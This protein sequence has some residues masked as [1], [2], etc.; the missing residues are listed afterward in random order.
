MDKRLKCT[1][2]KTGKDFGKIGFVSSLILLAMGV[3]LFLLYVCA[4]YTAVVVFIIS[5]IGSF[6]AVAAI[7]YKNYVKC[8][9][10]RFKD[11]YKSSD[12]F[13]KEDFM[14]F[15][16]VLCFISIVTVVFLFF[17]CSDSFIPLL[18]DDSIEISA[19]NSIPFFSFIVLG[20]LILIQIILR[21]GFE[22]G[23]LVWYSY[24]D[25]EQQ[26][27]ENKTKNQQ[28]KSIEK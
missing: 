9:G 18:L 17:I 2:E 27:L 7:I 13:V 26:Y 5:L 3:I 11:S 28:D 22:Q 10:K 1:I 12:E 23:D 21:S 6:C 4:H 14:D 16:P 25:Y 24:S 8:G 19:M 20:L 15:I